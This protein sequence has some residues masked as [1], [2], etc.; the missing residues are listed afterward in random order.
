MRYITNLSSFI[1]FLVK[2]LFRLRQECFHY[3]RHTT[4]FES[5]QIQPPINYQM[6]VYDMDNVNV[7]NRERNKQ[8]ETNRECRRSTTDKP[9]EGDLQHSVDGDSA[10]NNGRAHV[11]CMTVLDVMEGP[12]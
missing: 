8:I 9:R 12:R 2:L 11:S 6:H 10:T 4:H 7:Q 5:R 3:T 1:P